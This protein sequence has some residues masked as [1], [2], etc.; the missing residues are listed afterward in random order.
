MNEND[1]YCSLSDRGIVGTEKVKPTQ[2]DHVACKSCYFSS[3]VFL[4]DFFPAV[5]TYSSSHY[6]S[7]RVG[8]M[9]LDHDKS[10]TRR[11]YFYELLSS[12]LSCILSLLFHFTFYSKWLNW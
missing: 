4:V 12:Y 8:L 3:V 5:L 10:R 2:N 7:P 11:A 9:E 6:L 1:T